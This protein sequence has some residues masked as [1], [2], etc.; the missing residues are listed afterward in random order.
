MV[1]LFVCLFVYFLVCLF[2]RLFFKPVFFC[3]FATD[4]LFMDD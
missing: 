4:I 3:W 2:G 1:C